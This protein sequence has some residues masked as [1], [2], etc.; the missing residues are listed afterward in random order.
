MKCFVNFLK[1]MFIKMCINLCSDYI[2]MTQHFLN[3]AEVGTTLSALTYNAA[4]EP[5]GTATLSIAPIDEHHAR[6][7]GT[8]TLEVMGKPLIWWLWFGGGVMLLGTM[9]AAWPSRRTRAPEK[10]RVA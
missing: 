7:L 2:G 5:N 1:I 6:I 4:G 3:C 9:L 8:A 10:E